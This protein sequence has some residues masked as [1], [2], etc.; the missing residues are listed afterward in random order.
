MHAMTEQRTDFTDL[1]RDRRAEL[2]H[3]L[4]KMEALCVD[5]QRGEQAKFGWLSKVERGESVDPPKEERLKAIAAGY[6]LPLRVLQVAASRQFFGYDPASDSAAVWSEDLTTRIIVAHA[7]EM[8]EEERAQFAE[9][10][11]SFARR[12]AQRK[13]PGQSKSGE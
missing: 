6:Q 13:G 8:T 9:I 12:R 4:R 10:A 1:L 2:G 5:A 7:E 11:E 3:S